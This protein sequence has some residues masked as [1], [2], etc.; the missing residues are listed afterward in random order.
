M[1]IRKSIIIRRPYLLKLRKRVQPQNEIVNRQSI[2]TNIRQALR[3]AMRNLHTVE[4]AI[5]QFTQ[6]NKKLHQ[7]KT[8][9]KEKRKKAKLK[10][11]EKLLRK[12]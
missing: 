12:K 8:V 7:T 1:R 4:E 3:K 6:I 2:L 11:K 5:I 9:I 10:L